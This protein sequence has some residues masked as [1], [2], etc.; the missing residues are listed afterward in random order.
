MTSDEGAQPIRQIIEIEEF[1][2][3]Y[4]LIQ[5]HAQEPDNEINE[6]ALGQISSTVEIP[7]PRSVREIHHLPVLRAALESTGQSSGDR[8]ET[9]RGNIGPPC[10]GVTHQPTDAPVSIRERMDVVEPMMSRGHRDGSTR[11]AHLVESVTL[12]EVTHEVVD[13]RAGRRLMP[14]NGDVMFRSRPPFTWRHRELATN[15]RD[16]KHRRRGVS[17][18]LSVEPLNELLGCGFRKRPGGRHSID[19]RLNAHVRS[20]F[21]LKIAALFVPFEVPG[22]RAFDV[23]RTRVVTFDEIAVVGVH[24]TH[25]VRK[26]RG[27]ARVY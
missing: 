10:H 18:E 26:V 25:D 5:G 23:A 3:E 6:S 17:I 15:A 4:D 27:G 2:H 19:F 22:K 20:R 8:P 14:A 11:S 16:P 21:E 12:R 24:D 13:A 7:L 9:M 1:R